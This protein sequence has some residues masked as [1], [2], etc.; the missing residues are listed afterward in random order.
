MNPMYS[1]GSFLEE[2]VQNNRCNMAARQDHCGSLVQFMC[3]CVEVANP[4]KEDWP[5]R[6]S[7]NLSLWKLL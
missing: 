6:R 2:T 3:M 4:P 1:W 5:G 7:M